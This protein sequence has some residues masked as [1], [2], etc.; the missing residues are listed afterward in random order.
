MHSKDLCNS[1][2]SGDHRLANA[3]GENESANDPFYSLMSRTAEYRELQRQVRLKVKRSPIHRWGVFCAKMISKGQMVL[4]Y[5]GQLIRSSVADARERK[6]MQSGST[7]SMHSGWCYMHR[8]SSEFVIDATLKGGKARFINHSCN[9][10]TRSTVITIDGQP[11]I[12]YIA[13]RDILPW[14]EITT[15][16]KFAL[17]GADE[18][19]CNCGMPNCFTR[20]NR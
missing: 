3:G 5:S 4:E 18:L 15:D 20:M 13:I 8:L 10:N 2:L 6:D 17:A 11:R 9:P 1:L 16:Y 19:N 7:S 14:E 12:L